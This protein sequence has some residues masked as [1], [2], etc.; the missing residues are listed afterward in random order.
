[1]SSEAGIRRFDG[2]DRRE[3]ESVL[4][5]CLTVPRWAAEVAAGRPYG[6]W[7]ALLEAAER[8]AD[9]LTDEELASA[10]AGHPRIGERGSAPGHR[11]DLS[12][13]EQA[14]VDAQDARVADALA[15]GNAAYER[16]FGRVFI[17][18]AAGRNAEEVLAEL[19]R[20]LGNDDLTERA[21]TVAQLREIAVLRLQQA[22]G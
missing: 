3:A 22:V 16:R 14:G 8:A 15:A 4:R 6:E 19:D 18:R 1:V 20:R 10:L 9:R 13:R 12:E 7:P 2:L 5:A 11:A 21:E 17:I